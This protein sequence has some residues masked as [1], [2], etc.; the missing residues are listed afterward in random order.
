MKTEDDK[1]NDISSAVKGVLSML[2]ENTTSSAESTTN[3]ECALEERPIKELYEL[4]EQHK[5]HLN[6]FR[7]ME[8]ARKKIR[9][10]L[11]LM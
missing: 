8:C 2:Q 9:W 5:A 6:F 1:G 4:M 3:I 10:R 7:I 11:F